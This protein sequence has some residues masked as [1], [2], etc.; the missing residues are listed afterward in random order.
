MPVLRAQFWIAVPVYILA[1]TTL[2]ML[3][4]G[5]SEPLPSWGGLLREL[6]GGGRHLAAVAAHARV[7][8]GRGNHQP[9]TSASQK[10][11]GDMKSRA[12]FRLLAS[13]RC[14]MP[15]RAR[16]RI[17]FR[18]A[19]RAENGGS[20]SGG[21]RIRRGGA[22]P[23][24][25]FAHSREPADAA[26]EPEL[27]VSWKVLANGTKIVFQLRRRRQVSRMA[28]R[29][30]RRTWSTPSRN[31]L[32]PE[33][34]SP[35]ADTFRTAKGVA[36]V[37]AT[38]KYTVV[39]EFPAPAAQ[40]ERMFDQVSIVSASARQPSGA[41][42]GPFLIA[43]HKPGVS[44]LLRRNPAYWKRDAD[45][46]RAA[47]ARFHSYR[48]RA[49]SRSGTAALPPRRASID[50]QAD[51]RHRSTDCRPMRRARRWMPGPRSTPNFCGSIKS[52]R[53][54]LRDAGA[55]MVSIAEFPPRDFAGD[56]SRRSVPRGL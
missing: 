12:R 15:R 56:S 36:K 50:R 23:D 17:A 18:S 55:A 42:L 31:S 14:F 52:P 16:R 4:L 28:S 54:P 48:Y 49:E 3:G 21:R 2:G 5:V 7:S 46:K 11:S 29:S 24:R 27:A 20:F 34:H 41:G 33:L 8:A 26:P 6:E 39:A 44:I 13:V 1:E 19:G 40:I 43:E 45:G 35:I 32:A 9:A 51:A 22:L 25:R 38:G 53:A 30:L 37:S 47:A 10:G